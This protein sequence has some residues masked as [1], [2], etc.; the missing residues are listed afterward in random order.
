MSREFSCNDMARL[1]KA[2]GFDL[3][4]A[5]LPILHGYLGEL[6]RWNR[7]MNLV[8]ARNA[9]TAFSTLFVDSFYLDRFIRQLNLPEAPQC[10]DLGAGAGLPGIP[11]RTVWQVGTYTLVEAREKRALFLKTML[12][13]SPLPG[14]QVFHGRAENFMGGSRKADLILSRAF[15]PWQ[16]LLPFVRPHLAE[17]GVLLLLLRDNLDLAEGECWNVLESLT[18]KV[19]KDSRIIVALQVCPQ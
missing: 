5:A 1:A 10:W 3:P 4:E 15:M 9:E 12:A 17:Q 2:A 7:I 11:L 6:V 19:G 16:K 14:T 18:Y 8:G 13:R